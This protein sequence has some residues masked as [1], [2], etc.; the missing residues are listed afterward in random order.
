MKN[1]EVSKL[2]LKI[3]ELSSEIKKIRFKFNLLHDKKESKLNLKKKDILD[4]IKKRK[5]SALESPTNLKNLTKKDP[6]Y[7]KYYEIQKDLKSLKGRVDK[8]FLKKVQLLQNKKKEIIEELN[9]NFNQKIK[10]KKNKNTKFKRPKGINQLNKIKAANVKG[11]FQ[12][13]NSFKTKPTPI[14]RLAAK[15]TGFKY[16]KK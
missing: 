8:L 6:L 9:K 15:V 1:P 12:I 10:I 13:L 5:H 11:T 3:S 7:K 4:K 14:N 16:K 2:N